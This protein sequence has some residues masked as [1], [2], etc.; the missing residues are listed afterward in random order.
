M[1]LSVV[2]KCCSVYIEV[3]SLLKP[4][5]FSVDNFFI[6]KYHI[7]VQDTQMSEICSNQLNEYVTI[8]KIRMTQYPSNTEQQNEQLSSNW[9][10]KLC[11][12][13]NQVSKIA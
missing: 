11:V 5:D 13:C 4:H 3:I 2:F 9:Y 10:S 7:D 12:L 1:F 6:W 8:K